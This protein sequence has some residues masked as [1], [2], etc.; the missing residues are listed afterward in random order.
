M[1][2]Q[3]TGPLGGSTNGL[4]L[5]GRLPHQ[6]GLTPVLYWRGRQTRHGGIE[7]K[8]EPGN[9]RQQEL[10]CDEGV[11][12][13]SR[14]AGRQPTRPRATSRKNWADYVTLASAS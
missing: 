10:G 3:I 11:G 9:M 7:T 5:L 13:I 4:R 14:K 2:L 12:S 1:L 8:Q 6:M